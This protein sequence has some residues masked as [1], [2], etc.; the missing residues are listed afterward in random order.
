MYKKFAEIEENVAGSSCDSCQTFS[1]R[2]ENLKKKMDELKYEN[3]ILRNENSELES[4]NEVLRLDNSHIQQLMDT[5]QEELQY[6]VENR[7]ES[8]TPT[9]SRPTSVTSGRRSG[10]RSDSRLS[11]V[12]TGELHSTKCKI[13]I[14]NRE[15]IT[16]KN[17]KQLTGVE[18]KV[19]NVRLF[20]L[21]VCM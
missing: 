21:H 18:R 8:Q 15:S 9:S 12:S 2:F 20:T 17:F 13:D 1:E 19:F 14:E 5:R 7:A 6:Y 10:S 4:E 3:E 11:L 16:D